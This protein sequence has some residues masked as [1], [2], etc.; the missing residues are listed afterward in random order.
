VRVTIALDAMGGDRAP[1]EIV[2]GAVLAARESDVSVRLFGDLIAVETALAAHTG[3]AGLPIAIEH[4]PDVVTMEE[5]PLAA[6]RRKPRASIAVACEDVAAGRAEAVVS[7]GHTGAT[8]IAAHGALGRATGVD[9]PALAVLIPTETGSAVL[10]DAGANIDCRP[11]HLVQFAIMGAAYARVALGRAKPVVGLLSI[12]EE[13]GKG[14][15]VVRE[16]HGLLAATRLNF[17]GNLDARAIFTGATDVIVC[18]GF[19]GNVVLKVGE[20]LVAMFERVVRHEFGA[21]PTDDG[22]RVHAALDRFKHR[23]DDEAR[24]AAPLLGVNGLVLVAHGR[25]SARAIQHA[26][27]AAASLARAGF[28][29]QMSAELSGAPNGR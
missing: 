23:A 17:I 12:G 10:V 11:E 14:T 25:S 24:G 29:E 27:E 5:A 28:I 21:S 8:L 9:R 7:A 19:V 20:G 4:A 2:A 16:A 18:D 26:I 1:D 15:D 6:L 13:A 3:A 22:K